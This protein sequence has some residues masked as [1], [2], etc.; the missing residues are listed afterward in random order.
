MAD[1]A[2]YSEDAS[3]SVPLYCTV[4]VTNIYIDVSVAEPRGKVEV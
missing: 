3:M 4:H 1:N 2:M